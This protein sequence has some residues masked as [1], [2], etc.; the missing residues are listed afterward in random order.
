M[1]RATHCANT[2]AGLN[3]SRSGQIFRVVTQLHPDR[4]RAR[5][6]VDRLGLLVHGLAADLGLVDGISHLEVCLCLLAQHAVDLCDLAVVSVL[7][8]S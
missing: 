3:D 1:L 4:G 7:F 6:E 2:L 8:A 5:V